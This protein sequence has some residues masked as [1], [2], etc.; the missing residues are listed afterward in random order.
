M[1]Q[2]KPKKVKIAEC[3]LCY[4]TKA[5]FCV[6]KCSSCYQR[7]RN[8]SLTGRICK[9]CGRGDR[10]LQAR[11]LCNSCRLELPGVSYAQSKRVRTET[12][13]ELAAAK[14]READFVLHVLPAVRNCAANAFRRWNDDDREEAIAEVIALSWRHFV[15]A[16]ADGR[17]P[18]GFIG[19]IAKVNVKTVRAFTR[20]T[21]K[22]SGVDPLSLRTRMDKDV[23]VVGQAQTLQIQQGD[24]FE[25]F[26]YRAT[27][28]RAANSAATTLDFDEWKAGLPAGLQEFVDYLTRQNEI[29]DVAE[30]FDLTPAVVQGL[31][32]NLC[33]RYLAYLNR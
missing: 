1:R 13:E 15:H 8:K 4:E 33:D 20:L 9:G 21:G 6:G 25:G 27:G 32:D 22:T 23:T 28:G 16:L 31:R 24:G 30:R 19:Y 14:A 2:V 10:Q 11:G 12:A 18:L 5:I 29:A 26:L 17:D 3:V 7:E